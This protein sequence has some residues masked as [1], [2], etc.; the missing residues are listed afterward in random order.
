MLINQLF[1]KLRRQKRL[2]LMSHYKLIVAEKRAS[3][4]LYTIEY[5]E[6]L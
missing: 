2:K 6:R 4:H 1:L 3:L 5:I